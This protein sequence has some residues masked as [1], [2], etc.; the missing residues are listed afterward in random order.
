[1]S[2]DL[3]P[4]TIIFLWG[5]IFLFSLSYCN[6]QLRT[7]PNLRVPLSLPAAKG[8]VPTTWLCHWSPEGMSLPHSQWSFECPALERWMLP[9][10]K[11]PH[12]IPIQLPLN[13]LLSQEEGEEAR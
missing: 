4:Q 11:P 6:L 7:G 10:L 1:M 5:R 3:Q 9:A 13:S 8:A 2:M 12:L